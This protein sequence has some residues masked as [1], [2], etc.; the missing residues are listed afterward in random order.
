MLKIM[1]NSNFLKFPFSG[2]FLKFEQIYTHNCL[3]LKILEN[4]TQDFS[5][6]SQKMEMN[7]FWVFVSVQEKFW[8]L[9]K[10]WKNPL[11]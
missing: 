9:V 11:P 5:E 10:A 7:S 8:L 3:F 4:Y 6:E 1:E 2:I